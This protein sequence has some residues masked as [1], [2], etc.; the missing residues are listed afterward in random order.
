MKYKKYKRFNDSMLKKSP[1]P[2]KDPI[3]KS[4]PKP[5]ESLRTYNI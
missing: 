1:K 4:I 2:L 3:P 5:K